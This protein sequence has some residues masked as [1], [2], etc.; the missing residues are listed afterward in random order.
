MADGVL[1]P[2]EWLY[3]VTQKANRCKEIIIGD[4]NI[5]AITMDGLINSVPQQKFTDLAHA[6]IKCGSILFKPSCQL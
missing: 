2:K 1:L 4:T 5:K 3:N 6:S